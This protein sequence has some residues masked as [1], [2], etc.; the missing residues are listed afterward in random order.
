V[1]NGFTTDD[2]IKTLHLEYKIQLQEQIADFDGE[3][4]VISGEDISHLQKDELEKLKVYLLELTQP[5]TNFRVV[6]MCRHPVS[7]F[8][9]SIQASVT[10]FGMTLNKAVQYHLLRTN[11][12]RNLTSNFSKVF[13]RENI[14]LLK[15]EDAVNNPFGPA[16]AFL[17]LIDKDL[18]ERIKPPII[19]DNPT[20][21]Y[22]TVVLLDAINHTFPKNQDFELNPD[23]MV[24]LNQILSEMPGQKFM[25]PRG[26][27]GKAWQTLAVDVNW[28]CR[29]F[30]LPE[31]QFIDEDVN[32]HAD[33]WSKQTLDFLGA[34]LPSFSRKFRKAILFELMKTLLM[35][36]TMLSAKIRFRMLHFVVTNSILK[37]ITK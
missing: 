23:R 24:T 32:Y 33:L 21:T 28:L 37:F 6:M 16:G 36:S 13:G 22:E 31:Y 11:L 20:R 7:R 9:S 4:L 29:E 30:S 19:R 17:A 15:Y 35:R 3:T 10:A 26:K 8:R 18:P 1:S 5:E 2:A 27:S 14:S 34:K 12:Y 25:L